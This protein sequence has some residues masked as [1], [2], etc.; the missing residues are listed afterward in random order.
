M[1]IFNSYR[2][3]IFHKISNSY[4]TTSQHIAS[5]ETS[6]NHIS[7]NFYKTE[8]W[9]TIIQSFRILFLY[10]ISSSRNALTASQTNQIPK[11][12]RETFFT[13]I[14][15]KSNHMTLSMGTTDNFHLNRCKHKN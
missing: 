14:L 2:K 15:F 4:P 7:S 11:E 9:L 8:W 6:F 3:I 5:N 12:Y 13:F 1:I 10:N